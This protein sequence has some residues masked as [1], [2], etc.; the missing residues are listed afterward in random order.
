MG[1]R[2]ISY[3]VHYS[4]SSHERGISGFSSEL[5]AAFDDRGPV[6]LPFSFRRLYP[7]FLTGRGASVTASNMAASESPGLGLLDLPD[8]FSWLRCI[9]ML[10]RKKPDVVLCAYWT[11]LLVPLYL[12]IARCAGV[13][14]VM[15]MHNYR[16]HEVW[17]DVPFMRKL[18]LDASAGAVALSGYVGGQLKVAHPAMRLRTLFHPVNHIPQ[19][20]HC[21]SEARRELGFGPEGPVLL[22]FGYVRSYKGL[23]ILIDAMRLLVGRHE[24]LRLVVA[25]EFYEP[26]GRYRKAVH[27]AGVEDHVLFFPGFASER[28]TSL[29]F[30]ACDFV[31]LPYRRASQSGVINLAYAYGRPVIVSEA[32]GLKEEVEQGLTGWVV[33]SSTPESLSSGISAV[34]GDVDSRRATDAIMRYRKRHSWKRFSE[35]LEEFLREVAGAD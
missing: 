8:P 10:R 5:I 1:P 11:G 26:P 34:L 18:M 31:V 4:A 17:L 30:T 24:N 20:G 32:G 25:G 29:L 14:V 21:V 16:S 12:M 27:D 7:R 19:A 6:I 13:P 15:L 9:R 28:F 2:Q 22:F 33:D 3:S 35:E 23:D